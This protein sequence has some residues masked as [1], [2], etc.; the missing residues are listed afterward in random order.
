MTFDGVHCNLYS[1]SDT[2]AFYKSGDKFV[3]DCTGVLSGTETFTVKI[4]DDNNIDLYSGG[5]VTELTR[6]G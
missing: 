3:L 6:V 2:Y 1:P 4:V 5:Y